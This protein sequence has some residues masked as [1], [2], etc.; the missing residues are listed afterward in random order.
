MYSSSGEI[1]IG[2]TLRKARQELGVTL[3]DVEDETKIRK[4]YLTALEREDYADLPSEVY[5]RGF[6]KTYASYLGLDGEALSLDLKNRW[7][8]VQER[9]HQQPVPKREAGRQTPRSGSYNPSI[10]GAP[11][12]RR[13]SIVAII[14]FAILLALLGAAVLGLYSVGQNSRSVQESPN[15]QADQSPERGGQ[16]NKPVGT[17]SEEPT[18]AASD[19]EQTD[20]QGANIPPPNEAEEAETGETR[21]TE[22]AAPAAPPQEKITMD[23]TV[24]Q[25]PAWLNVQVD[26]N[27][28]YE[29]V[30]QPG[31]SQ[32]FE[33][34]QSISVWT[35]N[36]GA[37]RLDINGQDYGALGA[38]EEVK[39]RTFILKQPAE[40]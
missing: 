29:Q 31:F 5:A 12:R 35:G 32:T 39:S 33:A 22:N 18:N 24:A 34:G 4:R 38:P 7:E 27:T 26:G 30:T 1:E 14:G 9:R 11:N 21:P 37:V 20:Q 3:D 17:T 16:P 15:Q 19:P 13:I 28:V 2:A 8:A 25:V 36:A 6:L 40:G 10:G 23:V